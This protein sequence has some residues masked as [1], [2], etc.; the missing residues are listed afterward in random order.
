[1]LPLLI[2]LDPG[3]RERQ[4]IPQ[5]ELVESILMNYHQPF[6]KVCLLQ[7]TYPRPVY[8]QLSSSHCHGHDHTIPGSYS[9]KTTSYH[10]SSNALREPCFPACP[11][12]YPCSCPRKFSSELKTEA[13]VVFTLP[14]EL[15]SSGETGTGELRL[16]RMRVLA[17]EITRG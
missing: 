10:C 14:I 5:V 16:G 3:N 2:E 15:I 9:Y 1:M 6:R 17:I 12:R 7:F 8:Q 11:P 13:K 4:Q